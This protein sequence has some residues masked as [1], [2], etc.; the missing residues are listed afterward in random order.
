MLI[1][2]ALD[3]HKLTIIARVLIVV[4]VVQLPPQLQPNREMEAKEV[5][6][7]FIP[8]VSSNRN[9]EMRRLTL[10]QILLRYMVC[11]YS[12]GISR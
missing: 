7:V 2:V 4:D 12:L 8:A 9:I 10:V 11:S 6:S 1:T 3:T 5:E